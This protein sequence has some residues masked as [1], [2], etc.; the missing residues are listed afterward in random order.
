MVISS[1]FLF[2]SE[3]KNRVQDG[4]ILRDVLNEVDKLEFKSDEQKHELSILYESKIQNMGNAG[5]TGGQY[6][7]PRPLIKNIVTKTL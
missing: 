7:T 1:S 2:F 5:R 3:L 4:Y 6:Y